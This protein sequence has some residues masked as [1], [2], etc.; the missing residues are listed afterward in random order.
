LTWIIEIVRDSFWYFG[1]EKGGLIGGL[2]EFAVD[3]GL[4]LAFWKGSW[5]NNAIDEN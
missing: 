2:E 5:A 4:F 1:C 3:Y